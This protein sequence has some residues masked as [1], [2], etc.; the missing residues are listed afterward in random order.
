M[1]NGQWRASKL[2]GLNVYND[3]DEKLGDITNLS[4]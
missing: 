3:A 1:L 4:A 2:M